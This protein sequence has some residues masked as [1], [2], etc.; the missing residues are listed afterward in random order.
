MQSWQMLRKACG[1]RFSV[2]E[3][4]DKCTSQLNCL[5]SEAAMDIQFFWAVAACMFLCGRVA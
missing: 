3:I 2:V 5:L 1:G 4:G